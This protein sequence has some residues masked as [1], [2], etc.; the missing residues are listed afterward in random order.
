MR[1]YILKEN[2]SSMIYQ[3]KKENASSMH[4]CYLFDPCHI[5]DR[6]AC[7]LVKVRMREREAL[8]RLV[9]YREH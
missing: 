5:S 8:R 3:K 2:T 1:A 9:E 4:A 7:S 6:H